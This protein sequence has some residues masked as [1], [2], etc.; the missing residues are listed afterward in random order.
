VFL[1]H[2]FSTTRTLLH[3]DITPLF[4]SY[5]FLFL[6]E[7]EFIISRFACFTPADSENVSV[8]QSQFAGSSRSGFGILAKLAGCEEPAS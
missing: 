4:I 2:K 1:Y 3:N 7:T 6:L 8:V 5:D